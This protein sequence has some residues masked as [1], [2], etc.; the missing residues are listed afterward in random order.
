MTMMADR[1]PAVTPRTAPL[2]PPWCDDHQNHATGEGT[3]NT[4]RPIGLPDGRVAQLTVTQFVDTTGAPD[5]PLVTLD[6]GGQEGVTPLTG[7]I[8]ALDPAALVTALGAAAT[9]LSALGVPVAACPAWCTERHDP[10]S[11]DHYAFLEGAVPLTLHPRVR[12]SAE[13]LAP[14]TLSVALRQDADGTDPQILV[15]DHDGDHRLT[16]GEAR[17]LIALLERAVSLASGAGLVIR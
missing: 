13:K 7:Q 16:V 14:K 8:Q 10:H 2:C 15:G 6:H 4:T 17:R 11:P 3:H 9:A 1:P 12:Y 5:A